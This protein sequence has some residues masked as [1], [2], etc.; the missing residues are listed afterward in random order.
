MIFGPV[1]VFMK[2]LECGGRENRRM[3]EEAAVA[4]LVQEV[5]GV[6]AL[7][8]NDALGAPTVRVGGKKVSEAISISH[9][10]RYAVLAVGSCRLLGVDV[11]ENRPQLARVAPRIMSGEEVAVYEGREHG[12]L[13]AWTLKEAMYKAV[14]GPAGHEID[15][16][17]ELHLPDGEATACACGT[18]LRHQSQMIDGETMISVVW[19]EDLQGADDAD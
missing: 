13:E 9:S 2:N 8:E 16:A 6:G 15:F 19:C 4:A 14:R 10:A 7:K 12:L 11:E 18:V 17:A 5:F 1:R 3:R